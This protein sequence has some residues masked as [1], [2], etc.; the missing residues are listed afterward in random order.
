MRFLGREAHAY[1]LST[2][3]CLDCSPVF[4][5]LNLQSGVLSL[6]LRVRVNSFVYDWGEFR[7]LVETRRRTEF[8]E[9]IPPTL[10]RTSVPHA[11][12]YVRMDRFESVQLEAAAESPYLLLST[13]RSVTLSLFLLKAKRLAVTIPRDRPVQA[14]L[15]Y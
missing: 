4:N 6:K 8:R 11:T 13:I 15:S 3:C 9:V 5:R 12:F 14:S 10:Y 7:Y 1:F 2:D